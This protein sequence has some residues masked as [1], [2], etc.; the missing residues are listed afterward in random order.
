M[1]PGK[2]P[3][4]SA[5]H[6]EVTAIPSN[7]KEMVGL[8]DANPVPKTVTTVPTGPVTGAN[9]TF[10]SMVNVPMPESD[11]GSEATIVC[12]PPGTAGIVTEHEKVPSE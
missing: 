5:A 3:V 7:V 1:V 8:L 12:A 6:V 9:V 2:L 10:V 11:S 4:G